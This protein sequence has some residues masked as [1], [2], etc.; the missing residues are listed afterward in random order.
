MSFAGRSL[1]AQIAQLLS[2]GFGSHESRAALLACAKDQNR[3][4]AR[5]LKRRADRQAALDAKRQ[6]DKLRKEVRARERVQV[7]SVYPF[8][9]RP[10]FRP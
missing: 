6:Q 2:M 8:L 10:F 4:V 9:L 5:V 1:L 7:R 3:A